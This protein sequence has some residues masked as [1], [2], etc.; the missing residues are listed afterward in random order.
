MGSCLLVVYLL[1]LGNA[2]F[3]R[4]GKLLTKIQTIGTNM[5][6]ESTICLMVLCK[7]TGIALVVFTEPEFLVVV[8]FTPVWPMRDMFLGMNPAN[9]INSI[10]ILPLN[11][12][13]FHF[14]H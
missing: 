3:L 11:C 8:L 1:L 2:V 12:T 14:A 13:P 6:V 7:G 9:A 10:T 4:V 5:P